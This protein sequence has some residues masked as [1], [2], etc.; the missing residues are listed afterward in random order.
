LYRYQT[1][2]VAAKGFCI[3][4]K[5]KGVHFAWF[6][7]AVCR[8]NFGPCGR[9]EGGEGDEAARSRSGVREMAW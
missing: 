5:T 4:I 3:V 2:W 9:Q 7:R 8:G 1:K 6:E